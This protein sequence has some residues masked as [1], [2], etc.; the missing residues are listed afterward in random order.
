[1]ANTHETPIT[2]KQVADIAARVGYCLLKYGAEINRVEDTASRICSAYGMKSDV[3][4]I[5]SSIVITVEHE[6]VC[7]TQTR[8]I[9]GVETNLD[10]VEHFNAL[11]RRICQTRP[12][13][14]QV[15]EEIDTI[16]RRH[17]YHPLV[18]CFAFA[19]IGGGF[20]VFFG[21]GALEGAVGF[22]SG[23]IIRIIMLLSNLML[24]PAFFTNTFASAAT[25]LCTHIAELIFP[26]LNGEMVTIGVLMNLVPGILLTNCL[27]DFV[28]NDFTS[29]VSRIIEAFFVAAAIALGV[30]VS[31]LWR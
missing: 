2:L 18:S 6:G 5:A 12:S 1:M 23:F 16:E 3:F 4:A 7:F 14:P 24:A 20:A 15:I 26:A 22:V 21:G 13:Y 29:G 19:L 11:S 28:S 8:R 25:V 31:F 30:A 10:R 9:T 27:R 17:L